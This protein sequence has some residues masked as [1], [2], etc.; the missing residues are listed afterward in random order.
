MENITNIQPITP[1]SV[2]ASVREMI[3]ETNAAAEKR[4]IEAEEEAKKRDIEYEKR[5]IEFE[6][7]AKKRDIEF[8]KRIKSTNDFLDKLAEQVSGTTKSIGLHAE[9]Y[10]INSFKRG[11]TN[12]FGESFD[13]LLPN[14]KGYIVQD[15]YDILLINGVTAGIIEIKF[16]ARKEDIQKALKK[17]ITFRQNF[18]E[19]QQHKVYVA[20]AALT[21]NQTVERECITQGI[22]VIKQVGDNVVTYDKH[23]KVF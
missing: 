3:K 5:Q 17:V 8:E 9:D 11:Q 4:R 15:E 23:L 18:P 13:K 10:F 7:A 16:K 21:I 12:F 20:I 6:E 19:Y 1:E 2:L 14:A 22:A